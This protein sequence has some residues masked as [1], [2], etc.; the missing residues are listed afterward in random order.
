MNI[1]RHGRPIAFGMGERVCPPGQCEWWDPDPGRLGAPPDV[2]PVLGGT[3]DS[4]QSLTIGQPLANPSRTA[5]FIVQA[6]DSNPVLYDI[7]NP[8]NIKPIWSA[9][10][11]WKGFATRATMQPDGN[12]VVY[13]DPAYATDDVAPGNKLS[14]RQVLAGKKLRALWSTSTSGHPGARLVLQD[15]GNLVVVQGTKTLWS[16]RTD[17]FKDRTEIGPHWVHAFQAVLEGSI[18]PIRNVIL[19]GWLNLFGAGAAAKRIESRLPGTNTSGV[20][21]VETRTPPSLDSLNLQKSQTATPSEAP[22][23]TSPT[24]GYGP[25][26]QPAGTTAGVGDLDHG[27]H[28]GGGHGGGGR[29]GG[30]GGWHGGGRPFRGWGGG[31]GW[32][33][34]WWP[35]IV[36]APSEV[37]CASWGDPISFP[38]QLRAAAQATLSQ[39]GG[40]PVAIRG[41]DGGLYLLNLER[42][43]PIGGPISNLVTVRPCVGM[44]G[45]GN[46]DDDV[47]RAMALDLLG[48]LR[49]TGAPQYAT[50]SVKN[51]AQAWNAA[52]ADTQ[53]D[54]R[55]KYTRE[56]EAALNAALSALAPGSGTAP[57]AVL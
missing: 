8:S 45:V 54:T 18:I 1:A 46:S 11:L 43:M 52:S 27:G 44:L 37:A 32:G 7:R 15:D 42:A 24:S 48:S 9:Y 14:S 38:A 29:G 50:R 35:Y 3:L 20:P 57:A 12:F 5:V 30:R 33:G 51:F 39:S 6:A 2:S 25:Y 36:V 23:P 17:G 26:P 56:T 22:M 47:L 49:R 21:H 10:T 31:R 19:V 28:G 4:G 55:G 53:I 13:E 34:P 41:A 16:S 40:G